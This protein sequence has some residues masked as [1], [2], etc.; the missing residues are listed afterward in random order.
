MCP[1]NPDHLRTTRKWDVA[2][3][4]D[5]PLPEKPLIISDLYYSANHASFL[6]HQRLTT[7][8]AAKLTGWV[9]AP[10]SIKRRDGR[11]LS[12]YSELRV[13]G[14]G[15]VASEKSGCLLLSR[16]PGCGFNTYAQG[17]RF[18]IA[19]RELHSQKSDFIV[20]WPLSRRIFCSDR[21]R[22]LLQDFK[23]DEVDFQNPATLDQPAGMIGDTPIPP[24]LGE[25]TRAEI[26][27]FWSRAP[28][29]RGPVA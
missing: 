8:M 16:C 10:A 4:A 18:D 21:A 7:A 2:A 9:A 17:F 13:T 12:D 27:A 5:P 19:A 23:V 28:Q 24:H 14:F 6:L 29:N 3:Y 25:D 11:I 26:E 22:M 20:T 1:L 15:G